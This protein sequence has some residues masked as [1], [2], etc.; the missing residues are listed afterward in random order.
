MK[1]VFEASKVYVIMHVGAHMQDKKL[2]QNND[3]KN[4]DVHQKTILIYSF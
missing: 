3:N 2:K 1:H 4:K